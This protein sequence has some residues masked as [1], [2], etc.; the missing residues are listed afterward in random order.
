MTRPK[1]ALL[2]TKTLTEQLFTESAL[3]R[4]AELGQVAINP[5]RERLTVTETAEL[6]EGARACVT[7]WGCR[8]MTEEVLDAA[9]ELGIIVYAAG[10]VKPIVTGAVW[11]RGITVTSTAAM[12]AINVAEMTVGCVILGLKNVWGLDRITHS[13]GWQDGGQSARSRVLNQATIG[14]I[15]AGHVGQKVIEYLRSFEVKE[16]LLYDPYWSSDEAAELGVTAVALSELLRRSD[17]VSLHAPALPTTYHMLGREELAL[18]KD[19]A[20][21]INTSRGQ[22]IDEE[23]LVSELERG[24]LIALLDVTDPEPPALGSR[25]RSLP[26]VVLTPHISGGGANS[27]MGDCAVEEVRRFLAGEPALYEVRQDMMDRMA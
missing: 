24:R 22:N 18:L 16:I 6:L 19:D 17:V 12:I 13:G 23:A 25:L 21:L 7:S 5:G 1:I 26:N 11:K 27:R 10:S 2:Q 3:D 15:G 4:M 14:I 9:P 20:V 8:P